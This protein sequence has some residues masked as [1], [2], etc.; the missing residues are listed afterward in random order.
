MRYVRHLFVLALIPA[1]LFAASGTWVPAGGGSWNVNANWTGATFPNGGGQAATLGASIVV[2]STINLNQNIT[3]ST[4]NVNNA[5]AYTVAPNGAFTLTLQS[6]TITVTNSN[7]NGAH[8]ITSNINLTNGNLTINQ[9]SLGTL[10]LSGVISQTGTR[11]ITKTGTQTARLSGTAS[12]TNTGATVV[13]AGTLELAKTAGLNA[14]AGNTVTINGGTLRLINANQIVNTATVTQSSGAFDLN[15]NAEQIGAYTFN[16]GTYSGGGALLSLQST[17]TALTLGGTT[18]RTLSGDISLVGAAGGNVTFNGSAGTVTLQGINLNAVTRTFNIGNGSAAIDVAIDGVISG[19]GGINK[20]TGA[21]RLAYTGSSSNSYIGPTTLNAGVL[22][23]DKNVGLVACPGTVVLNN[24]AATLEVGTANQTIRDLTFNAGALSFPG[25]GALN[26]SNNTGTALTINT[27]ATVG[28]QINLTGGANGNVTKTGATTATLNNLDI[29]SANRIFD[30]TGTLAISGVLSGVGG[31]NKNTSTGTLTLS[32]AASNTLTGAI[33][34]NAGTL[35]LAKTAPAAATADGVVL[36]APATVSI[37]ATQDQTIGSFTYNGGTLTFPATRAL[38]LTESVGN[39]LIFNAVT[40]ITGQLNLTGV[41]GGGIL[42]TAAAAQTIAGLDLGGSTRTVNIV[43]G[44]TLNV[45]GILSGTGGINKSTGTGALTLS[46]TG[47]N[48][49]TGDITVSAGTLNLMKTAPAVASLGGVIVSGGTV[50]VATTQTIGSLTFNSGTLTFPA[51]TTLNLTN[52]T[53]NAL[54]FNGLSAIAGQIN[55]TGVGGGG[56]LQ[57]VGPTETIAGLDLGGSTRTVDITAGG[58]L[59]ISGVLSGTGGI[60]KVS[61]GTLTLSGSA[62]NTVTGTITVNGGD[63]NLNKGVGLIASAGGVVLNDAGANLLTGAAGQTIDNLVYNAGGVI[64]IGPLNLSNSTGAAL[65]F[66]GTTTV[67]GTI[68]LTGGAGGGNVIQNAVGTTTLN[69]LDLGAFD[70]TFDITTGGNLDIAGILSSTGG[71]ID[72]INGGT[73]TLSGAFSNTLTTTITVN[74][75]T[76]ALD[77]SPGFAASAGRVTLNNAAA[78]LTTGVVPQTIDNLFYNAGTVVLTG[79]LNLTNS[80]GDGLTFNGATT[81]GGQINLTGGAG[82]GN[83]L[84]TVAGLVTLNNLDVGANDRTFDIATGGTLD[85]SAVLSSAGGGI[86]KVNGGTLTL[87]NGVSNTLATTITIDGGTLNLNKSAGF[88]ASAGRVTVNNGAAILTTGAAAQTIDNLVYDSGTVL[89]GGA[90]NL[91]NSA[92]DGLLFN[93]ATTINGQINLTGGAGGGGVTQTALATATL[94]NLDLG[95]FDRTFNIAGG[96]TLEVAGILSGTGGLNKDTG[97][98]TLLLSGSSNNTLTGT[99]TINAGTVTLGK[100]GGAIATPNGIVVNNALAVL[101][102]TG[103]A[104]TIDNLTYNAGTVSLAGLPLN[105]SNSTGNA[106]TLNGATTILGQINLTGGA[107]GGNVLQTV[108]GTVTLGALDLGPFD[109]TIDI[110]GGGTLDLS[111]ILSGS[112]GINQ[113]NPGTLTLSGASS[114]TL[115]GTITVNDGTL[116]LNKAAGQIASEGGVTLVGATSLLTT[117]AADQTIDNLIFNAGLVTLTGALNLSNSTGAALTLNNTTTIAGQINLTG[118]AGGGGVIQAAAGTANLDNLDLG[119]F[120]RDFAIMGGG[121]LDIGGVLSGAGGILLTDAGTLELSGAANNTVTGTLFAQNG[122]LFLNKNAGIIAS[123]GA[124]QIDSPGTLLIPATDQ[125]IGSLIYNSGT[126]TQ[127]GALNLT[128]ALGNALTMRNT[129]ITG[130][131]NLTGATSGGVAFDPTNGGTATITTIDLGT[132]IRT[133]DIA[134]GPAA[135]DMIMIASTSAVGGG[136]DKQGGGLLQL[137]GA[138]SYPGASTV[139]V[140]SGE[141]Q[142]N[143][144]LTCATTIVDSGA[145][146]SGT[147]TLTTALTLDGT[148]APG[149]SIGTLFIVGNPVFSGSSITE[150][151]ITPTMSDLIDITGT[152]TINPGATLSILPQMATYPVMFMYQII[153]TTGGITGNYTNVI[154]AFPLF[155]SNVEI[156]GNDMFL[157]NEVQPFG[158]VTPPGSNAAAVANCL[159]MADPAPGSDLD[160]VI[161]NLY[162][163]PTIDQL[164][165]ALDELQ[166]SM[167][168]G[169]ALL[170]ENNAFLVSQNLSQRLRTLY[171]ER[172]CCPQK[173]GGVWG[174]ITGDYLR[175]KGVGLEPGFRGPSIDLIAGLD[176]RFGCFTAGLCAGYSASSLTWR[177]HRGKGN[178]YTGFGGAYAQLACS[179]F[180]IDGALIGGFNTYQARRFIQFTEIDRIARSRFTGGE[181]LAHLGLATSCCRWGWDWLPFYTL[182]PLYLHQPAFTETGA[183]SINC[184]VDSDDYFLIRNEVGLR[185]NRC[186]G[187]VRF[188]GQLAY[189]R[190]DRITGKSYNAQFVSIP[191]CT[192]HVKGLSPDRNLFVPAFEIGYGCCEGCV[193]LSLRYQAQIGRRFWDQNVC[194][195][196]TG[197]L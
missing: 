115:T 97:L 164:I 143:G 52:S 189:A 149:N 27:G 154:N 146:L 54:I 16:G 166:P 68:N 170:Q 150:I 44:G 193:T 10:N 4:L 80:V 128:E 63:L 105:L 185:A 60:D 109:R 2:P 175:Q 29:G 90:L 56:I 100:S 195:Q 67:I 190:E 148:I 188:M 43:A 34:V 167:L 120:D 159:D 132:P 88:V 141:L 96:G 129:T 61:G 19:T 1:S 77:K 113:V 31:I 153:S 117:G 137:Q 139:T 15:G 186:C 92:G 66:N 12:N 89:L 106:L 23:L 91:S 119:A 75:G 187:P 180:I 58:I 42:Q 13:T 161:D 95:A 177:E 158:P 108:A 14:I 197:R 176:R 178:L 127:T 17:G 121:T 26:L 32:G 191:D 65:T 102:L 37:S 6:G 46:G 79:P 59:D 160:T 125:T 55:L 156:I 48:T 82:G 182:N 104:Q 134:D 183:D 5:N 116:N 138:S 135:V 39:A 69:F 47:S 24:A 84:Q 163:I 118:G 11:G 3:I 144:T 28:G 122:T 87:S 162:A 173:C 133:F 35:S 110:I 136:F 98:G 71:G 169:L 81:I 174:S 49:V 140:S 94:E 124:V 64:L 147:G 184:R 36:N 99:I 192:M 142:V 41:G 9:N 83:I 30:V 93:G 112:G 151:E 21:G 33:T 155:M 18:S 38:N 111:G 53:G 74:G 78:I 8:Q 145:R 179:R 157:V 45:T 73:L 101:T 50:T 152:L 131:I 70:R 172:C 85:I 40:P 51:G 20:N 171:G 25:G 57:T 62:S 123:E 22:L 107:G 103:E 194:L 7:G 181:V 165:A 130:Q 196:L 86:D 76:L 72:K 168:K 126:L 114:N